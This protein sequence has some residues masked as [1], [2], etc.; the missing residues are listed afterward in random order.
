MWKLVTQTGIEPGPLH[1]AHRVL[2]TGPPGKSQ[3]QTFY[4]PDI[5]LQVLWT[6]HHWVLKFCANEML[7]FFIFVIAF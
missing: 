1:W 5:S 2:A 7:Q 4:R 6:L 3:N